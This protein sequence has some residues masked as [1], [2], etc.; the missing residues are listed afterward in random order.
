MAD[1]ISTYVQAFRSVG[2]GGGTAVGLLALNRPE[3]LLVIGAGQTQ[4]TGGPRCI[5]WARPTTT[6]MSSTTPVYRR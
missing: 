2:A 6:P 5:R 4:G 3:V 1:T